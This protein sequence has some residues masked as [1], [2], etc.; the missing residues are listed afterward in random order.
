MI[1]LYGGSAE[2]YFVDSTGTARSIQK[3]ARGGT[4]DLRPPQYSNFVT[5]ISVSISLLK[6]TEI[7]VQLDPTL[8][9]AVQLINSGVLGLGFAGTSEAPAASSSDFAV[10]S[11]RKY[12]F[13]KLKVRLHYGGLSSP[14]YTGILM[15]P[16]VRIGTDGIGLELRAV[17]VLFNQLKNSSKKAYR[18]QSRERV[19]KEL[20]ND[21]KDLELVINKDDAKAREALAKIESMNQSM[22]NWAQVKQMLEKSNLRIM[23][24]GSNSLD[25]PPRFEILSMDYL[26]KTKKG[27]RTFSVFKQINPNAGIFPILDM[28]TSIN[29]FL[30]GQTVGN[31]INSFDSSTKGQTAPSRQKVGGATLSQKTGTMPSTDGSVAGT[32]TDPNVSGRSISVPQGGREDHPYLEKVNGFI[33][34]A[35][36]GASQYSISTVGL[37]DMLPGRPANVEVGSEKGTV[38]FLTGT[39]DCIEIEHEM[40]VDGVETRLQLAK[41]FGLAPLIEQG[42]SKAVSKVSDIA[43]NTKQSTSAGTL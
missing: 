20:T 3:I 11:K 33:Q 17:G 35:I 41:T 23:D 43:G 18:S 36:E 12:G 21:G 15:P 32:S 8:Q 34:G 22:N 6:F 24:V 13:N 25:S 42:V 27:V 31:T 7:R 1:D 40:S 14:W 26:R 37:V 9:E 28:E 16:N 10:T 30:F 5:R 4:G 2:I 38:K 39:Y 29:N 19:L